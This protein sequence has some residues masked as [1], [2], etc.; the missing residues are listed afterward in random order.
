M[1]LEIDSNIRYDP[2]YKGIPTNLLIIAAPHFDRGSCGPV[3][4]ALDQLR[5]AP[6][7]K[8]FT[9]RVLTSPNTL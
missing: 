8:N 9:V 5:P 2:D 1:G 3:L 7:F 4:A 6:L